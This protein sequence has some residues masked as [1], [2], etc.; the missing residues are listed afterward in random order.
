[1][2][3][4]AKVNGLTGA[5][6]R[7][8][9][10]KVSFQWMDENGSVKDQGTIEEWWAA[11][12]KKRTTY[13]LTG[14]SQ[15]IYETEQGR[16][17]SGSAEGV[18]QLIVEA[19]SAIASPLPSLEYLQHQT[20]EELEQDSGST[21]LL[22]LTVKIPRVPNAVATR[23]GPSYCIDVD[24]PILRVTAAGLSQT[25]DNK[26]GIFQG[27]YVPQEIKITRSGKTLLTAHLDTLEV[28]RTVE[29]ADF[30]PPSDAVSAP[31]KIAISSGV[32]TG[33][34]V[35]EVRPV[36]P[37]MAKAS[38][39]QGTVV[40]QV[41]ISKDGSVS[42]PRVISGPLVLQQAA[43]DAV[44]QWV[45]KPYILNGEPVDVDTTINLVFHLGSSTI[46][47]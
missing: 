22:C 20:I 15:T 8:W 45:Y 37:M 7:P 25:I 29:D 24:K 32:A 10:L 39:T 44:K 19:Q 36:Y 31:R 28:L 38:G 18:P 6:I 2:Q 40:L 9:H 23:F 27:R 46:M 5:D 21:K 17:R 34:L 41:R 47:H 26:I 35:K 30:V 16:F 12:Q 33:L 43:I 11:P 13:N 3:L 4:A 14:I 42:E 1:M